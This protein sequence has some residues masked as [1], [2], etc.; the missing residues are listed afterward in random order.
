MQQRRARSIKRE[1]LLL[2]RA[3]VARA[4]AVARVGEFQCASVLDDGLPQ[5]GAPRNE[6]EFGRQGVLRLAECARTDAPVLGDRDFLLGGADLDLRLQRAAGEQRRGQPGPGPTTGF[7]WLM[8]TIRSLD[9]LVA[10]ALERDA[11]QA[12]GLDS[13]TA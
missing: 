9:T 5:H 2:H 10:L 3:Q 8:S 13:S 6:R 1:L 11:R 7:E 12:R 4:H